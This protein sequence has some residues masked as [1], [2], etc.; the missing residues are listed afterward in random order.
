MNAAT[1][2]VSGPAGRA[3]AALAAEDGDRLGCRVAAL[4]GG[5]AVRTWTTWD[6][7]GGEYNGRACIVIDLRKE[8]DFIR[9]LTVVVSSGHVGAQYVH[10]TRAEALGGGV[11]A[12]RRLSWSRGFMTLGQIAKA[13]ADLAK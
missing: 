1:V 12:S 2:C 3:A 7:S 4:L 5:R 13:V 9:A 10:Q 11:S 6:M 8:G